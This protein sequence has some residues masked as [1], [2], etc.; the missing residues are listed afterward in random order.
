M[1]DLNQVR[2][3]PD[4]VAAR[5]LFRGAGHRSNGDGRTDL[6]YDAQLIFDPVLGNQERL[7]VLAGRD[8]GLNQTG[9]TDANGLL[10]DSDAETFAGLG[11]NDVIFVAGGND[12]L[13]GGAGN[14]YLHGGAGTDTANLSGARTNYGLHFSTATGWSITDNRDGSPD[15]VDRLASIET[16]QFSDG[17]VP[18]RYRPWRQASIRRWRTCCA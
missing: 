5:R 14:D 15:G 4:Y 10:G 8:G 11:G 12:T 9:D 17:A 18:V 6:V 13:T 7:T 2:E 3:P 1:T 16:L